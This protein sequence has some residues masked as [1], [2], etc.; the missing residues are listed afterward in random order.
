MTERRNFVWFALF[1]GLAAFVY[2]WYQ[3]SNSQD[4]Q[5]VKQY[6]ITDD[7]L[8][9]KYS[10]ISDPVLTA[11]HMALSTGPSRYTF[12]VKTPK[13]RKFITL[14]LNKSVSPWRVEEIVRGN[15]EDE[16]SQAS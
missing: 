7:A 8:Q 1:L 15:A 12:W 13:G 10:Q 14:Q 4:V 3:A 9:K 11:F 16:L 5:V 6:L 2:A